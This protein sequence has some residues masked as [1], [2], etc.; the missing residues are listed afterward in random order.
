MN[1]DR[2]YLESN[3]TDTEVVILQRYEQKE[4]TIDRIRICQ[5]DKITDEYNKV[6]LTKE[7]LIELLKME[8]IQELL[9]EI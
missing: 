2:I 8:A 6:W 7:Q 5:V 3:L 1:K 9:K 4:L